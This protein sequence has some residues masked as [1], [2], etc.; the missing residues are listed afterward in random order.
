MARAALLSSAAHDTLSF[1]QFNLPV[2]D[3]RHDGLR[4][5]DGYVLG[6][7]MSNYRGEVMIWHTG[8]SDGFATMVAYLPQRQ[9]VLLSWPT[10]DRVV[11]PLTRFR[12][13]DCLTIYLKYRKVNG[14]PGALRSSMFERAAEMH[15]WVIRQFR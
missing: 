1:P 8:G 9:W 14:Y 13:I 7:F 2:P 11:R 6:R 4:G 12:P 5:V 3:F 10:T 15:P